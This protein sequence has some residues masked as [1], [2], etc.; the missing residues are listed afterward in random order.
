MAD[1]DQ[2]WSLFWGGGSSGPEN[3]GRVDVS[4]DPGTREGLMEKRHCSK[5]A[6]DLREEPQRWL[7]EQ[8]SRKP[9]QQTDGEIA[10]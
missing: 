1:T 10:L 4:G 7:G 6:G 8:C 3:Q 9:E 5:D 2:T